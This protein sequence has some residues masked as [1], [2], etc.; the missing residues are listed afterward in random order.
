VKERARR[1][2]VRA[3]D[4]YCFKQHVGRLFAISRGVSDRVAKWNGVR[5][6]VLHPPPAQRDYRC[7]RYGDFFFFASRLSPLK[8]ADLVLRALATPEAAGARC[9]IAGEGEEQDRLAALARELG[10]GARA[11][12]TGS[13]SE[14]E[15]L[16]YLA[17]CRAV[18]F[19]PRQEDYGFVTVEAF[20][21]SK[22]VI[23]CQDSGGPLEL[24][25]AGENGL[26]VEPEPAAL[27]RA[28]AELMADSALA[29]RLGQQARRD[30][31]ALSWERTVQQLVMV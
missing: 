5:A 18:V 12:L 22:A 10:L 14:T 13:I 9:V 29:E 16:R 27:G 31:E 23:T 25:R 20:A 17:E 6:Q 24:V 15:L 30:V 28:M 7:D 26:V 3:V 1:A 21:A 2:L 11:I 4:S 8:R 19:V